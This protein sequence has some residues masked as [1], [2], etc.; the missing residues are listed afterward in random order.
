M[1]KYGSS[2][3]HRYDI[4]E[5]RNLAVA[6]AKYR[7]ES[8][9]VV[10]LNQL[11]ISMAASSMAKPNQYQYRGAISIIAVAVC[12]PIWQPA[13]AASRSMAAGS[14]MWHRQPSVP[15]S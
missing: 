8:A 6:A 15:G 14:S 3:W 5:R 10:A 9:H 7:G 2:A 1:A 11:S 12:R 13:K 4:N